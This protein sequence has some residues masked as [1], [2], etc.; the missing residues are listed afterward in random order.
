MTQVQLAEKVGTT[1][2]YIAML[3]SGVRKN[4][5]LELLRRMAKALKVKVGALLT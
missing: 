3:E 2:E 4:P 5:S 1:Q